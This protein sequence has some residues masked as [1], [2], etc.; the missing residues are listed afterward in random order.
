MLFNEVLIVTSNHI[1]STS[2]IQK[3]HYIY[4]YIYKISLYNIFDTE[5]LPINI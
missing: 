5:T 2:F 1:K 4:V 3:I